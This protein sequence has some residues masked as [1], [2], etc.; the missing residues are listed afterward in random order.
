MLQLAN[1]QA[2][3]WTSKLINQNR[4]MESPEDNYN[5]SS[6][7]KMSLQLTFLPM[8]HNQILGFEHKT[9]LTVVGS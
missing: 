1:N 6:N 4:L 9:L 5:Q 3:N 7:F 2:R 8:P